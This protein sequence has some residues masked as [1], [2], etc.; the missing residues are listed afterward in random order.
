MALPGLGGPG[1][2]QALSAMMSQGG[3][4]AGVLERGPFSPMN[5]SVP[6]PAQAPGLAR[7]QLPGL[8]RLLMEG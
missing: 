8:Q 7:N 2:A 4:G 5:V 1:M 6:M 3:G